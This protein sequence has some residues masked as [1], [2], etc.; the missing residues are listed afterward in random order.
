MLIRSLLVAGVTSHPLLLTP[1]LSI[2]NYL[3]KPR[4]PLFNIEKNPI[5][6]TIL[7]NFLYNH[8]CAGENAT[9]VKATIQNIKNM[10]FRGVILTYAKETS[11]KSSSQKDSLNDESQG[12]DNEIMAW[13]QGVLQT[14]R[15]IGD[16]DFLALK[17]EFPPSWPV[18]TSAY[19]ILTT[20]GGAD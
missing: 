3:S 5:L 15:M 9:E 20:L 6:H 4:G 18:I 11:G 19:C 12:V 8:F 7:K 1:G 13:H 14:I 16:G 17:Y 2:L 10:G